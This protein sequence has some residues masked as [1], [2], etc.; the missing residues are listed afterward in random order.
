MAAKPFES[1]IQNLV[2]NVDVGM[3]Y[4]VVKTGL[5]ILLIFILMLI[6]TAT[7]F[8]GLRDSEAM[9]Y[10]QIGRQLAQR[11]RFITQCVRPASM[12][13]L[14]EHSSR[15]NPMINAHPDIL[16]APLWPAL[17]GAAFKITHIPF[18]MERR[19][20]LYPP[21]QWIVVPMGHL[22]TLLTGVFVYLLAARLFD[23]RI[24]FVSVITFFLSNSVWRES[25]SGVPT[26]LLAFL[27][28]GAFYFALRAV[29]AR[30]DGATF[31]GWFL[32]LAMA[33]LFCLLTA[34]TRYAA[35]VL[36]PA[37]ALYIGISFRKHRGWMWAAAIL[38]TVLIGLSPW[39]ARNWKVS[40]GLLGLAPYTCLNDSRIFPENSFERSLAPQI[41]LSR[42]WSEVQVKLIKGFGKYFE[43][44]V[45]SI[46]D[47]ILVAFFLVAFFFRF[48]R[49][50]V[51]W[52]RWS[53]LAAIVLLL[54]IA[55]VYGDKTARLFFMFWPLI[56]PFGFAFFFVLL[57]R[58]QLPYRL[59]HLSLVTLMVLL[60]AAPLL[61]AMMP[62][63]A[64]IPY[65]P[66]FP[67]F[68]ISV[69]GL[70][71]PAEL[72]CTDMPWATAWYGQRNSV[73]LPNTLDEFY[74]INDYYKRVS[75]LY[76]TT[77]TRDKPYARSLLT[78]A[79]RTWFPVLEGRIPPDF[80][81][82]QGF[83][84]N[85]MDQLFLTDRVRWKQQSP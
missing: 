82:T 71:E 12:W 79:E 73:L 24:A 83:P 55:A 76:F 59:Y 38:V 31:F 35:I 60:S 27:A 41:S 23:Q 67:P 15:H 58:L 25:I 62:P 70:L 65:P 56:I 14:I 8:R 22:F 3:G 48:V 78:G 57:D 21:E 26:P 84:L 77:I 47:G 53:V 69:S 2:Y 75:G 85:N 10:A 34:L 6:Y 81:L 13:Y 46:G 4:R 80:P 39:L 32:P 9:D 50:S 45:R 44:R 68:V 52:M 20:G 72:M 33:V 28:T 74:E 36:T 7:Q 37:V 11:H 5:F 43:E 54:P 42:V 64:S 19:G 30:E 17:L 29:T 61:V 16:H 1:T 49:D 66:Y 40:G 63:R 51:H 18:P